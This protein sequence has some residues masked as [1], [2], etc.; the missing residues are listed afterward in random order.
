MK[1]FSI[2]LLV[3]LL[4][5]TGCAS[6]TT[7]PL[8]SSDDADRLDFVLM[9]PNYG[10][11]PQESYSAKHCTGTDMESIVKALQNARRGDEVDTIYG[12]D[13]TY[14]LLAFND[15]KNTKIEIVDNKWVYMDGTYYSCSNVPNLDELY[16][17]LSANETKFT[18]Y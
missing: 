2:F 5:C 18:V 16:S 11:K 4:L 9:V 8:L 13:I 17:S 10:G 14:F 12:G 6:K 3:L 1:K 7:T 15:G